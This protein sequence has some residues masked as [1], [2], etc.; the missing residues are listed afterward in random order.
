[1]S[2]PRSWQCLRR[3][4][5]HLRIG[6]EQLRGNGMLVG[7]EIKI[8]KRPSRPRATLGNR[9]DAVGA[10]ELSHDQPAAALSADQA[11]KHG[12]GHARHRGKN[13]RRR[14]FD[15]ADLKLFRE[16]Q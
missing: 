14:E 13:R 1:M 7:I 16:H 2:N 10:G 9:D 11:A 15:R 12:V 6:P 5:H 3:V 4:R 8:A